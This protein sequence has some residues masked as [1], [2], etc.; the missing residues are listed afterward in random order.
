MNCKCLGG[1]VIS[2]SL[3][4]LLTGCGSRDTRY[5]PRLDKSKAIPIQ[6]NSVT[7]SVHALSAQ[8]C[9]DYFGI[10][11]MAHGYRPLLM[12]IEN[13]SSDTYIMRPSYFDL[14]RVSGKEI[15]RLMHYDTY[16]RVAWLTI[17][18]LIY[19]WEAIPF[20]IIPYGFACKRYNDKTTRNIR[21]K[22]WGRSEVLTIAPYETIQKFIFILDKT[23]TSPFEIKL[24]NETQRKLEVY[25]MNSI[26]IR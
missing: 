19:L 18:A 2:I 12:T 11:V 7:I 23:F 5:F 9:D 21:K 25:T 14:P 10:D 6:K 24:Y 15:S 4:I 8:D 17:P 22:T 16:S 20:L 1:V 13:H 26:G 3:L